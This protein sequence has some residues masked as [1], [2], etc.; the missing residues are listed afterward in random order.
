MPLVDR[1][2]EI[3]KRSRKEREKERRREEEVRMR[4]RTAAVIN[5]R[6]D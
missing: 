1:G 5:F 6:P 3:T 2:R 4:M